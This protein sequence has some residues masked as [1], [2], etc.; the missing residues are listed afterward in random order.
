M[1][2]TPEVIA[3]LAKKIG[4]NV[5]K[6]KTYGGIDEIMKRKWKINLRVF[7]VHM[8]LMPVYLTGL[9]FKKGHYIDAYLKK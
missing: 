6:I 9:I 4:F 7:F 3:E 8:L 1:G 2:F 5:I